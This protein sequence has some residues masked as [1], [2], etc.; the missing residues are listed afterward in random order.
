MCKEDFIKLVDATREYYKFVK[1]FES[2]FGGISI[3]SLNKYP[4]L[5]VQYIANQFPSDNFTDE[6]CDYLY[7]FEANSNNKRNT[8]DIYDIISKGV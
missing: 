4:D 8:E 6:V 3:E 2:M 7:G 1:D 5:I